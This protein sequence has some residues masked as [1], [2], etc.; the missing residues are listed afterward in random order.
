M[1]S[2]TSVNKVEDDVFVNEEQIGFHLHIKRINDL[3]G[4]FNEE[5]IGVKDNDKLLGQ[6]V[7]DEENSD[8]RIKARKLLPKCPSIISAATMF[9]Y[10]GYAKKTNRL[11]NSLSK[12]SRR[13]A[14]S[15]ENILRVG[16]LKTEP[17]PSPPPTLKR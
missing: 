8:N 2:C 16:F 4:R 15:H 1:P 6:M 7:G 5:G 13:Y 10:Y 9:S 17:P 11:L 3:P 12:T 14:K